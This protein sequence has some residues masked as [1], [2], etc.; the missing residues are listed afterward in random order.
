M[1]AVLKLTSWISPEEYL[2][3]ERLADVRHEYVDG[4]VYAMAGA[5]ANHNR[6]CVNITADLHSALRGKPCEP[7]T[8]EMKARIL[9]LEKT[10]FYYPDVLICC[11]PSDDAEEYRERPR[12]IFEVLSDS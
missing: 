1:G 10:I 6:I 8:T 9:W 7:F 12:V 3:G 5:K 4:R 11:D 2:E